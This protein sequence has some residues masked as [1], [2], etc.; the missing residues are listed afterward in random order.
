MMRR[1]SRPPSGLGAEIDSARDRWD[2]EAEKHAFR[3]KHGISVEHWLRERGVEGGKSKDHEVVARKMAREALAER[4]AEA[5]A[6]YQNLR[7]AREAGERQ[8]LA[9]EV[10]DAREKS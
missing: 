4:Q 9:N 2:D 7:R 10:Q 5:D 1:K 6:A 8:R 3:K